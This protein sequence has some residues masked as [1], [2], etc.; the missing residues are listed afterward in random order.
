MI[1]FDLQLENMIQY[2]ITLGFSSF[3][4]T[5]KDLRGLKLLYHL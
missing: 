4:N 2:S 3:L 1:V 5:V